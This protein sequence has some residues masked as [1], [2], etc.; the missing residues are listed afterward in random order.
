MSSIRVTSQMVKKCYTGCVKWEQVKSLYEIS[1][2]LNVLQELF[3]VKLTC[4]EFCTEIRWV[5]LAQMQA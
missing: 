5:I 4:P 2:L 3:L 1:S